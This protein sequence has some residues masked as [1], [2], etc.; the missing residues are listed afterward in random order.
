MV[1]FDILALVYAQ[2]LLRKSGAHKM[3]FT[4]RGHL[5]CHIW[6]GLPITLCCLFLFYAECK[7][8]KASLSSNSA[9][10]VSRAHPWFTPRSHLFVSLSPSHP[11]WSEAVP[12][13]VETVSASI[14]AQR[15]TRNVPARS[16]TSGSLHDHNLT[17][18]PQA[19]VGHQ[20]SL[21]IIG[22]PGKLR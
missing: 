18:S 8:K 5:N 20:A 19:G 21:P 15:Y 3:Y 13:S 11:I 16:C 12:G 1:H 14:C 6:Q 10:Q 2:N 9:I 17:A 22:G 7:Y 4:F